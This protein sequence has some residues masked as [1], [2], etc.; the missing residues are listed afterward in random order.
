MRIG[1]GGV[2]TRCLGGEVFVGLLV[3]I[4]VLRVNS[5]GVREER[6]HCNM[7]NPVSTDKKGRTGS[8]MKSE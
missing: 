7:L 5:W 3:E 2:D 6:I 4:R 1:G 8:L